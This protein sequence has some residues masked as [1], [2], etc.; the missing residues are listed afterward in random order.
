MV[1]FILVEEFLDKFSFSRGFLPV[2]HKG[3]IGSEEA[4]EHFRF[5]QH[6]R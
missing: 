2:E 5:W 4:Y 1:Y 6:L 3:D